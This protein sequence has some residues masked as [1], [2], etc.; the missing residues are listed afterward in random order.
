MS[1]NKKL[2]TGD[3]AILAEMEPPKGV[4]VSKMVENA[5]KVKGQVDA[6]VIPEMSNAV[7]RMSS[8]GGAMLLQSEGMETV[9]QVCCRDRNRLALQADILAANSCGIKSI[10]AVTGEDP[11]FGDHHQAASV[12]D[13]QLTEL[14]EAF[15]M[16]QKGRDMADIELD[17]APDFQVGSVVNAGLKGDNLE[18]ELEEMNK[19]IDAGTGFF[20]TPP[21]F[22]VGS[23]ETFMKYA[24]QKNA[25]IIPTVLLLKSVG[26]ARYM[27]R[28]LEHVHIP[29]DLIKRIQKAPDKTR[30]CVAIAKETIDIL[31]KEGFSGAFIST[32]GWEQ[33]LPE[34]IGSKEVYG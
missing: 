27:S 34:I 3:F 19:K 24:E 10:M 4:N 11:S 9:M 31:R 30:E 21:L 14:L 29:D 26:M 17:G 28:N 12:Y 16:L 8:L 23:I 33:R 1:F 2:D 13:I 22:D 25:K 18:A 15:Q 20:I 7:M 6:F 5:A 32:L